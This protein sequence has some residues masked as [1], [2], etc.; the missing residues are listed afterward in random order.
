MASTDSRFLAYK[1]FMNAMAFHRASQLCSERRPLSDG[2]YES[3][4]Q[5]TIVNLAF[6]IELYLKAIHL[7]S[8]GSAARGHNLQQLFQSIGEDHRRGI[9]EQFNVI[10]LGEHYFE[11]QLAA[12][13]SAF[14]DWR[15]AHEALSLSSRT[16]FLSRFAHALLRYG[17]TFV[18]GDFGGLNSRVQELR[19]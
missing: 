1:A 6:A 19:A 13:A 9:V 11:A 4:A 10:D 17:E 3:L 18:D 5:P 8:M 12:A 7:K 16:I 14:N 15:Y 2:S